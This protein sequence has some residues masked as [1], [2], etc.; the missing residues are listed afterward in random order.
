MK[1]GDRRTAFAW[2]DSWGIHVRPRR[3]DQ[4]MG[5]KPESNLPEGRGAS[6]ETK[7]ERC[8]STP[9][10]RQILS[11]SQERGDFRFLLAADRLGAGA[12]AVDGDLC[13][14]A[15]APGGRPPPRRRA[16]RTREGSRSWKRRCPC[17]SGTPPAFGRDRRG[18]ISWAVRKRRRISAGTPAIPRRPPRFPT[19]WKKSSEAMPASSAACRKRGWISRSSMPAAS[20]R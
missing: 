18:A 7:Q 4:R 6:Q 8:L 15:G 17:I 13:R 20:R 19:S 16:L 11:R 1:A 10:Y 14:R 9:C 3:G 2:R 12:V 5:P